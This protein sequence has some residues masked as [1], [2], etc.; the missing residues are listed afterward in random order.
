[1][2]N[3]Q[4]RPPRRPGTP[5]RPH[6]LR[7]AFEEAR[8]QAAQRGLVLTRERRMLGAVYTLTSLDAETTI[9]YDLGE[10]RAFLNRPT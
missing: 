3:R 2:R 9:L 8:W 1:M 4:P 10:V 7:V 6:Q 5:D